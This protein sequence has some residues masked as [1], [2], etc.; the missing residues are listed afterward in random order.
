MWSIYSNIQRALQAKTLP[1][2]EASSARV[3]FS[4]RSAA[5]WNDYAR[6]E[7]NVDFVNEFIPD[8][9]FIPSPFVPFR[10]LLGPALYAATLRASPH[11]DIAYCS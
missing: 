6:V 9:A 7:G 5:I 2:F 8:K 10:T 3:P 1:R 4:L 11:L